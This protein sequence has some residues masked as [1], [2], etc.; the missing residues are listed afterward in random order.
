MSTSSRLV[1][2]LLSTA[3]DAPGK[4]ACFRTNFMASKP[5]GQH[6]PYFAE[7]TARRALR[8]P[9]PRSSLCTPPHIGSFRYRSPWLLV[10][11]ALDALT[12]FLVGD[13][14]LIQ[15]VRINTEEH[16]CP[17]FCLSPFF[18]RSRQCGSVNRVFRSK[19]TYR[20]DSPV[21]LAKKRRFPLMYF[22]LKSWI[23][24]DM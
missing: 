21:I 3:L 10:Q 7:A 5:R 4:P 12:A 14:V 11:R 6:L 15:S 18:I 23:S 17:W 20:L 22:S 9:R 19:W 13:N 16:Q 8:A 1:R 2:A 24:S